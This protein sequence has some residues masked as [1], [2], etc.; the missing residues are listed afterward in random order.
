M[1]LSNV[2]RA[3]AVLSTLLT[4]LQTLPTGLRDSLSSIAESHEGLLAQIVSVSRQEAQEVLEEVS[5]SLISN[6]GGAPIEAECRSS[7]SIARASA[8]SRLRSTSE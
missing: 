8:S 1:H 5:F 4:D 2:E 6:E 3:Q 7:T